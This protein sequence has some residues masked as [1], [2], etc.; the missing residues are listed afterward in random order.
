MGR[1]KWFWI[2]FSG[3]CLIAAVSAWALIF[4]PL[5]LNSKKVFEFKGE[6]NEQAAESQILV[7]PAPINFSLDELTAQ[8]QKQGW[9]CMCKNLN[10][11]SI[12]L[13][14]PQEYS[15]LLNSLV[16]V[17]TFKNKETYRLL[18]LWSD[19]A[20]NQT[21][22]WVMDVPQKTFVSPKSSDITFP[23]RPPSTALNILDIKFEKMEACSWSFPSN[24]K[25]NEQF[26]DAYS[27]EGFSGR[28][29]SRDSGQSVYILHRGS[30][31]LLA[32]VQADGEKNTIL[33]VKV[34]KN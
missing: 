10:L 13:D 19:F 14:A 22:Q 34:D 3:W 11:A 8:Y 25:P 20:H 33:V 32:V 1:F 29:W 28:L 30:V 6:I 4:S 23:F 27:S 31:K 2:T 9:N 7:S 18:G 16:Q 26:L 15:Q 12:L 5:S 17:R 24:K 21:Y